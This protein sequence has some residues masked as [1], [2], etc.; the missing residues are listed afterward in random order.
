MPVIE[1]AH[2]VR[3]PRSA[4]HAELRIDPPAEVAP[5]SLDALIADCAEVTRHLAEVPGKR[6]ISIPPQAVAIVEDLGSYGA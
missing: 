6:V 4:P 3:Q 5:G 2:A 1:S